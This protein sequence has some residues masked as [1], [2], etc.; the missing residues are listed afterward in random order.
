MNTAIVLIARQDEMSNKTILD[1]IEAAN[2]TQRMIDGLGGTPALLKQAAEANRVATMFERLGGHDTLQAHKAALASSNLIANAAGLN[3]AAAMIAKARTEAVLTSNLIGAASNGLPALSH[4]ALRLPM[5]DERT[6][7][8]F[9]AIEESHR[10]TRLLDDAFK[11]SMIA[12]SQMAERIAALTEP[13]RRFAADLSAWSASL[14]SRM[15]AINAAWAFQNHLAASGMAFGQL[16]RLGDVVRYDA[17]FSAATDDVLIDELG[18]VVADI[19]DDAGEREGQ[20][21]AAGRNPSL[22][23]F[24]QDGFEGVV[25][26]AGFVVAIP[27]APTPKPIENAFEPLSFDDLHYVALRELEAHLRALI[28]RLMSQDTGPKWIRQRVSGE[29]FKKWTERQTVDRDGGRP[30]FEPLYYAD[31]VEL[32]AVI[33]Q[34]NNWPLFE[35]YFGDRE[36]LMVSLRRLSPIRNAVAH[37]RP[38]GQTDTLYIA[39]EATRLLRAMRVITFN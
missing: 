13:H 35:P 3:D 25:L 19:D 10:A 34:N 8:A 14:Q 1:A 36:S 17:P 23:A 21:D 38:L 27:P 4:A 9:R 15:D 11:P 24:P 20:Y 32:G 31:F 6:L 7:S 28:G 12:A 18:I 16:A 29:T 22:V 39:A 2:R 33:G 37:G 26:A 30:V 5:M